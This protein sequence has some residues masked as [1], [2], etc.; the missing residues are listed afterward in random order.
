MGQRLIIVTY[1]YFLF[2]NWNELPFYIVQSPSPTVFKKRL[3]TFDFYKF[4]SF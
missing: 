2:G 3:A 1:I 4:S